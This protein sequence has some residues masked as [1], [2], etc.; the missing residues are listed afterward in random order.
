M[1]TATLFRQRGIPPW[2]LVRFGYCLLP[3][4]FDFLLLFELLLVPLFL[5]LFL[6]LELLLLHHF[7][8]LLPFSRSNIGVEFV[9][10]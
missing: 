9:M 10:C 6:D 4:L 2:Y 3:Q 1:P 8:K 5:S 7:V